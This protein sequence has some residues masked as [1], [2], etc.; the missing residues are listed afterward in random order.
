[1]RC[2]AWQN[3]R[4]YLS[5]SNLHGKCRLSRPTHLKSSYR[6]SHRRP[7]SKW[8]DVMSNPESV[9]SFECRSRGS[10]QS[11]DKCCRRSLHSSKESLSVIEQVNAYYCTALD[12][13]SY[14]LFDRFQQY[15]DNVT[16]HTSKIANR[17]ENQLISQMY[18]T[19]DPIGVLSSYWL[20]EWRARSLEVTRALQSSSAISL[21]RDPLEPS[22]MHE[23]AYP[24]P[25]RH[26]GRVNWQVVTNVLRIYATDYIISTTEMNILTLTAH[27]SERSK[28]HISHLDESPTLQVLLHRITSQPNVY[29]GAKRV[30]IAILRNYWLGTIR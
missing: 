21:W 11:I 10:R 25:F 13:C 30:Y 16:H 4:K 12:Y 22:S 27:Q 20:S 18:N 29:R 19:S 26:F 17:L 24:G 5:N 6:R 23:H 3:L 2:P 14:R 1:M 28:I 9:K 8:H 7:V 15:D